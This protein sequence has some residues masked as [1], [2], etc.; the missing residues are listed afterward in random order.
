VHW[1]LTAEVGPHCPRHQPRFSA[2]ATKLK[3]FKESRG[4]LDFAVVIVVAFIT[5]TASFGIVAFA[6]PCHLEQAIV[7]TSC[8][9]SSF[10]TGGIAKITGIVDTN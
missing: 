7:T 9:P 4:H 3:E 1:D 2:V 6:T 5:S 10:G 8:R